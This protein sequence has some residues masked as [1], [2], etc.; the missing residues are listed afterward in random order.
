MNT[1]RK[2]QIASNCLESTAKADMATIYTIT[3]I[4]LGVYMIIM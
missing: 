3:G 1:L 2:F 4:F